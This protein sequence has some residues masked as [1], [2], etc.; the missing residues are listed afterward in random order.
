[1]VL[2]DLL[3]AGVSYV[4]HAGPGTYLPATGEW[5]VGSVGA[6]GSAM[7][8][9]TVTV[10]AGTAGSAIVNTAMVDSADQVDTDPANDTAAAGIT[11]QAIDI[12][13][14]KTVDYATPAEGDSIQ[15]VVTVT[16]HGPD[17]A[18]GVTAHDLLPAGLTPGTPV[19]PSMGTTYNSATGVWIIGTLASDAEAILTL[20]ATVNPGTSGTTIRNVAT[21]TGANET[22]TNP[23][24]DAGTVD[25][26]VAS[27]DIAVT[28][29]VDDPAPGEGDAVVFTV[30]AMNAGMLDATGVAVTDLLPA[31]LTYVSDDAGGA[32]DPGTGVWTVGSVAAG[33]ADTLRIT[34]SV[35]LGTGD[36][37]LTNT[38][39]LTALDQVDLVAANDSASVDVT[40]IQVVG[41][42]QQA[43]FLPTAYSLSPGR[44]NPFR[45][46]TRIHFDLPETGAVDLSVFDVTGRRVA[47]LVEGSMPA[48]RFVTAWDGHDSS[49]RRV[50]AG[51][52]FLRLQAGPYH[53]VRKSV[54]LD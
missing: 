7:L 39:A 51:V 2:T 44:P 34:A 47:T 23:A 4:T 38:A 30:A 15:F 11:V 22:D 45:G 53:E 5:T 14:M 33:G 31:G 26:V 29:T 49:G 42:V 41:L 24:N 25:V 43:G 28:K 40:V 12:G 1:V 27:A 13:V 10:D 35:D 50:V 19:P 18:T 3:P 52:Y 48:G 20:N 21:F 46:A 36:T 32:Y 9:I 8:Q 54:R 17:E 37:M 16:N 6:A